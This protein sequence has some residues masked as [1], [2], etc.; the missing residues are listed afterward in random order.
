M[1][2]VDKSLRLSTP[3]SCVFG[4]LQHAVFFVQRMRIVPD[5]TLAHIPWLTVVGFLA[6][7]RASCTLL[8][9][10]NMPLAI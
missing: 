5:T 4:A 6:S 3:A 2:S 7:A 10:Y 1:H 9:V 8:A